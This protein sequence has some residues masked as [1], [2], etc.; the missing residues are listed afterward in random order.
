MVKSYRMNIISP[1]ES[2]NMVYINTVSDGINAGEITHFEIYH[3]SKNHYHRYKLIQI[4][5]DEY[6]WQEGNQI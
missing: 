6:Y 1:H 4:L 5:S 2:T 3:K